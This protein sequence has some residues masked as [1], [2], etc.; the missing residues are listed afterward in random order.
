MKSNSPVISL[1]LHQESESL[2]EKRNRAVL[3]KHLSFHAM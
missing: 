2:G 1:F 3:A